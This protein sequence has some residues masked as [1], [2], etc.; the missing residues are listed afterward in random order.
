[1]IGGAGAEEVKNLLLSNKALSELVGTYQFASM[2]TK[3]PAICVIPSAGYNYPPSGTE[4]SGL[5]IAIVPN[6]IYERVLNG[7]SIDYR[8]DL[9]LKQHDPSDNCLQAI[10]AIVRIKSLNAQKIFRNYSV[11]E[12]TKI[13]I[14][15]CGYFLEFSR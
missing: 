10:D 11:P 3:I 1:M 4:V 15:V 6:P 14:L 2:E 9:H 12:V 5:E 13:E 7:Y 8:C